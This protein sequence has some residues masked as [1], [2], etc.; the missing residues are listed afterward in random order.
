MDI[1]LKRTD[2][3]QLILPLAIFAALFALLVYA[4][5]LWQSSFD[6]GVDWKG[7]F[8]PATLLMLR[9]ENPYLARG[10]HNP[11][12]ALVP[13]IPVALLPEQLGAAVMLVLNFFVY[14]FVA[15]RLKAKPLPLALF[16]F[17]PVVIFCGTNGNIDWLCALGFLMPPQIGLFF[18]LMKPQIGAALALFWLV[19]GWQVGR[20]HE[21]ARVFG[22]LAAVTL[23][24]FT[25]YGFWPLQMA[26]MP[27]NP[28]NRSMWPF[29]IPVGLALLV[30]A[31]RT[32]KKG[33]SL[34]AAPFL[35]PYLT[36]HSYAPALLGLGVNTIEFALVCLALWV[37]KLF[38]M[39]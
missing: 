5:M 35:S 9:G 8:R 31:L 27:D 28:Y 1:T 18:V 15:Y 33:L 36:I 11:P 25:L 10:F 39:Y 26:V 23:L 22:P 19:E 20:L 2:K 21:V 38:M 17:T 7:A 14:D 12:W 4:A 37:M 24:S 3:S 29:S 30:Y 32:R 34:T 16:L 13:L 6:F